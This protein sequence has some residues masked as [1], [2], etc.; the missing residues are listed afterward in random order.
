MKVLVTGGRDYQNRVQV[1][2]SLDIIHALRPIEIV[3]HG[4]CGWNGDETD[5]TGVLY[6]GEMTG[7]DRWADEWAIARK[8]R[9]E[10][11]P[12]R[13]TSFGGQGGPIRNGEMLDLKPDIVVAFPGGAGTANCCR[14]ARARRITVYDA[15]GGQLRLPV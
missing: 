9:L 13:W 11:V 12:A 7:A 8:V 5:V 1:F 15:V 14:Q 3:I 2:V 10:R 6:L 4:A